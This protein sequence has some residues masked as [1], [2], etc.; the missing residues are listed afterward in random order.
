M[1]QWDLS[2]TLLHS[3][4]ANLN[5]GAWCPFLISYLACRD[6]TAWTLSYCLMR[7]SRKLDWKWRPSV[8]IPGCPNGILT[9]VP[10]ACPCLILLILLPLVSAGNGSI[11]H[12]FVIFWSLHGFFWSCLSQ[13]CFLGFSGSKVHLAL[14]PPGLQFFFFPAALAASFWLICSSLTFLLSGDLALGNWGLEESMK[15]VQAKL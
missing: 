8:R 12:P 4:N 9:F 2:S 10:H 7:I 3:L 11:H 1:R 15:L 6:P 5:L 13:G 14:S